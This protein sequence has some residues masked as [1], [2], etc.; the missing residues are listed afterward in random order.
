M[1]EPESDGPADASDERRRNRLACA[2]ALALVV[3]AVLCGVLAWQRDDAPS[4]TA[5]RAAARDATHAST[6]RDLETLMSADH[7]DAKATVDDWSAVTTGRLNAQL[8]R[9]QKSIVKR[10]RSTKEVTTVRTV[11]AALTSWDEAAGTARL[12]AVLELRTTSGKEPATRTVR[13]LAMSQRVDDEWLLSAV[14]QIG[15]TS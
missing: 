5:R 8:V 9:Q 10:L 11:D 12:L 13:Y 4:P 7:R 3:S 14:Q 2:L 6:L 15:A 1:T